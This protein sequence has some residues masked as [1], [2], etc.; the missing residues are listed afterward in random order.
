MFWRKIVTLQKSKT[1]GRNQLDAKNICFKIYEFER[2]D[3]NETSCRINIFRH[4]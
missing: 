3:P 1:L 2:S 4:F